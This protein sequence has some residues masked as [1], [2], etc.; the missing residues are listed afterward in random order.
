M[1]IIVG[2]GNPGKQYENTV[3]NIGFCAVDK[4]ADELGIKFT[5][6]GFKSVYGEGKCGSQKVM[7]VK[8]QT[9]MN[10]SGEAVVMLKQKFKDGQILV[11]VDDIDTECGKV[12]YRQHGS[13]GTHNGLR[14]IVA[15]I[16]EDFERFK[17]GVGK[18]QDD[19]KDFVLG[20]LESSLQQQLVS[21]AVARI[22][23]WING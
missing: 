10:S 2:L 21:D 15:Y 4:L 6:K 13:G 8:P 3:H 12:K 11:V 18:P 19:L 16:G 17:L 9:Y 1:K 7:L 23:E 14:N 22:K 20:R 5:K